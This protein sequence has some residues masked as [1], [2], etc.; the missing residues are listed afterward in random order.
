MK[1]TNVPN[2]KS[3]LSILYKAKNGTEYF[4]NQYKSYLYVRI[5]I[6]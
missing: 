4:G 5:N 3:K 2:D 6:M 1:S